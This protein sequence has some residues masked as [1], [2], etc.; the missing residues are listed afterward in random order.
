MQR[1][2]T[3]TP[4][5]APG[6]RRFWIPPLA[7][8]GAALVLV[9]AFREQSPGLTP[10]EVA[11][12]GAIALLAGW[13][14]LS[15]LVTVRP[16]TPPIRWSLAFGSWC[17]VNSVIAVANGIGPGLWLRFAFPALLFPT[18]LILGWGQFQNAATRRGLFVALALVGAIVVVLSLLGLRSIT[19]ADVRDLQFLRRF[20]GDYFAAFTA[21]A[22]LPLALTN[23]GRRLLWWPVGIAILAIGTVG[24]ALSFTRTYWIA[25]GVST[26]VLIALLFRHRPRDASAVVA[27]LAAVFLIA[28]VLLSPLVPENVFGFLAAR[29]ADVARITGVTSLQERFQESFA[30]LDAALTNPLSVLLGNGFGAA[31]AYEYVNPVTGVV[32]GAQTLQ[33]VH[34]YYVYILFVTG[35]VGVTLYLGLWVTILRTLWRGLARDAAKSGPLVVVRIATITLAVNFLVSSVATPHFMNFDW[36]IAFGL[37]IGASLD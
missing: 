19:L 24:L 9:G 28:I 8:V 21:A 3:L 32:E 36:A 13:G 10:Q 35:L 29:F 5:R 33:Y 30:V 1:T 23:D 7:G 20:A 26:L 16:L 12:G 14:L 11:L 22:A 6:A 37:L 17:L 25:T 27:R 15:L 34:N 31:F 4:Q 18:F 2:A